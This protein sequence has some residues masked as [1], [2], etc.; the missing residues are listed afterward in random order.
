MFHLIYKLDGK[1]IFYWEQVRGSF[2][3]N[4]LRGE[5]VETDLI[6]PWDLYYSATIRADQTEDGTWIAWPF[7][8][9]GG[10]HGC[11]EAIPWIEDAFEVESWEEPR[12]VRLFKEKKT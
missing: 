1:L 4:S 9:G 12:I 6:P 2:D 10:K 5:G 11:P 8:F 7:W 3:W